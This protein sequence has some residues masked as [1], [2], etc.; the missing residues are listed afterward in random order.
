MTRTPF[1]PPPALAARDRSSPLRSRRPALIRCI[2]LP[3]F[4]AW[5][6]ALPSSPP[7][8]AQPTRAD[9]AA[10]LLATAADFGEGGDSES[11]EALYR[12]I[13]ERFADT[14]AAQMARAQLDAVSA[15]RF[16]GGGETELK[17]WSTTAG[18]WLGLAVPTALDAADSEAYGAGLLLGAPAGFL[19]SRRYAASRPLSLGQARAIT[20]GGTW[21]AFHGMALANAL[22]L[23]GELRSGNE[24]RDPETIEA[25]FATMIAGSVVGIGAGVWAAGREIRPGTATSATLGTLWGAWF[26][27]ATGTLMDLGENDMWATVAVAGDLGLLA[28][29]LAGSR[30]EITRSRARLVSV[31]GLIG[32]VGAMGALLLTDYEFEDGDW[33]VFPL[34]GSVLGLAAGT[35]LT[36]NG[37]VEND[38]SEDAGAGPLGAGGA[39]LN[40]SGGDWSVAAPVPAPVRVKALT[41]DGRRGGVG[42]RVPLF[43]ARF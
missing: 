16:R 30:W 42:W 43:G 3:F 38:P 34:A 23:G 19:L 29:T 41:G 37:G 9:S 10:I 26:G 39:L 33:V 24:H 17:V 2:A 21:G 27:V 25:V 36:R 11:A 13:L 12:H 8:A 31:G 20:W 32:G 22:D 4:I 5:A 28:G 18:I 7:A 1:R 6:L 40:W 15:E 14:P 35:A